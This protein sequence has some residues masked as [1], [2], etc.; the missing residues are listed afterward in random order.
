MKKVIIAPDSFKGV[1]SAK[2]VTDIIASEVSSAFPGCEIVKMPIADGG[3][4]SVD[5]ILSSIGGTK[6]K[7]TVLS[8]DGRGISAYY[9]IADNGA[10]IM[11]MALSSGITRQNGLHPMTS[12]TYGFGQL[13]LDALRRGAREF[14]LGIGG[15][16]TTDGGCGMAA[17]LG[18]NFKD[19]AGNDFIP[20]G[21]T[22][23]KINTI[24]TTGNGD[25]SK[26][27]SE[28]KFTVMC[29]VDN[30]L[31]GENG[32]AYIYGPQKGANPEQV[33]ILDKGLRHYSAVLLKTFDKDFS[34]IPGAGAAGGL[35][36]G[37]VAFLG[38]ELKSGIEAI[39]GLCDFKKHITD[40]DLVITGEGKL[41]SQSFQGKVLSGILREAGD[42]PV[43]SICGVSDC[44][45]EFLRKKGLTVFEASEGITAEESINEPEKY[46]RLAAKRA[47]QTM[48]KI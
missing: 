43:W 30:P 1:L 22:L 48:F 6:H 37:C 12:N 47:V 28:S 14:M 42:V 36:A 41:D 20:S 27:I 13:I 35:G 38:A 11:E 31:F 5:A 29:D 24:D 15:S 4:G 3:E 23:E 33:K 17:A 18:I 8:P 45:K 10:A 9:G 19:D 40:A 25:L 26:L 7:A 46:L 2:E 34:N 32:A 16:A 21:E 39:L 44:D